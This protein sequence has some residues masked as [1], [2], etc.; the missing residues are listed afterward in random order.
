MIRFFRHAIYKNSQVGQLLRLSLQASQLESGL[1]NQLLEEPSLNVKYL[2]PT[3]ILSMRQYMF[4]HNITIQINDTTAIR[5]QSPKDE[6][7]MN[8]SRLQAYST[9]AQIDI[10]LVRI[11][12]QATTVAELSDLSDRKRISSTALLGTRSVSFVS[13]PGWPRQEVPS[14]E[15]VKL[16]KLYISSQF[17]QSEVYWKSVPTGDTPASVPSLDESF[18]SPSSSRP[19]LKSALRQLPIYHRRM[20][21]HVKQNVS[22]VE[23]WEACNTEDPLT[24]A[25][26]GGLKG[27]RGTFGWIISSS[28]KVVLFEGA[29]PVDGP[30][31][32]ASSTR[33]E[34]GGFAAVLL[35][36][37]VLR[38]QWASLPPCTYRWVCD[39]KAAISN[40][41]K[42]TDSNRI[43]T[44][45]PNNADYLGIIKE[46]MQLLEQPIE[47]VWVKGH[48]AGTRVTS[49]STSD[50]ADINHNNYVDNLATW[51]RE[52]SKKPQS[53]EKSAHV[54]S[55]IVSVF[56]NKVRLVNNI[57]ECIRFHT[58][59][60][61]LRQ[62][63]Q[64]KHSWSD[65]TWDSIDFLSFGM[66][67][68]RLPATDQSN[69]TKFL[70]DQQA[71]GV[72][73]YRRATIKDD[74]LHH[75]PCC[76][77]PNE[78]TDHVLHCQTNPGHEAC[79]TDLRKISYSSD[80]HPTL[81]LLSN[82]FCHWIQHP[83]TPYTP[84]TSGFPT[85]FTALIEQALAEQ[86]LIGWS[87]G[88]RGYLSHAWRQMASE[89]IYDTDEF[90]EGRGHQTLRLVYSALFT[91]TTNTWQARNRALHDD[92]SPDM[93]A[94][95]DQEVAVITELYQ[96][97]DKIG[98]TDRHYCERSLETILRK[99]PSSRRRW[100]RYMHRA[101]TRYN[102]ETKHQPLITSFFRKRE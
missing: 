20:L 8:L 37:Q 36:Y 90:N 51:Y 5:L 40:T 91:Y 66:F 76:R 52:H 57:E 13:N 17:L 97:Q 50:Q 80:N 38:S 22:D 30:F 60:Y 34:L 56:I 14:S 33:S 7:I 102:S 88:V 44:G 63:T 3:W 92:Q 54:S 69:H 70:F 83:D 98:A 15:Q 59:G 23:A 41:S 58:N 21:N 32:S 82:G 61:H 73:R 6:Y 43:T 26:D 81:R 94:I 11:Y 19:N 99:N 65:H 10:N 67:Y 64:T 49:D 75:C 95:R 86:N 16:W 71:V 68:K 1:P 12:L 101:R 87:Q 78:S 77:Q 74:R 93:R 89:G 39:S 62:Y 9:S 79:L 24:F 96:N 25:T 2:T 18:P 48:Q 31:D 55:A 42:A 47:P 85:K 72:N 100:I 46:Q 28:T 53:K 4:N 27:T 35:F 45:Q 84:D 29:G